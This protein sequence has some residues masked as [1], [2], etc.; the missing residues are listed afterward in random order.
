MKSWRKLPARLGF[1]PCHRLFGDGASLQVRMLEGDIDI[2]ADEDTV[3]MIGL[4]GEVYPTTFEKFIGSYALTGER[5]DSEFPYH[6]TVLNKDTGERLSLMEHAETCVAFVLDMVRAARLDERVKVF[7]RW[8]AENYFTGNPGDWLVSRGPDDLYVVTAEL[9]GKL[10]VRDCTD[11]DLSMENG[12][13]RAVKKNIPVSVVFA[14]VDGVF[15]T[16][17]GSVP[18]K[19]GDTLL[20]GPGGESWPVERERFSRCYSPMPGVGAWEEG[21]YLR[22]D[23]P[24]LALR[25]DEP[26]V[27]EIPAG[28][29]LRGEPGDWLV[30]YTED[31]RG[32]V[33]REIFESTWEILRTEPEKISL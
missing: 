22:N 4:S 33:G 16:R 11:L 9:F 25:M 21:E 27:T 20:T 13:V 23:E 26:F 8:D 30:R 6:P 31:D 1:V 10:Y 18:Y 29:V 3:L 17:E 19:S 24:V 7:T 28:G 2:D 12:T 32:I 14:D 15:E 5:F